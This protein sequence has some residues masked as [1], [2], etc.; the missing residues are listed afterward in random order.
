MNTQNSSNLYTSFLQDGDTYIQNLNSIL[1]RLEKSPDSKELVTQAFRNAHSLKS[2]AS[3]LNESEIAEAAHNMES[4]LDGIDPSSVSLD[5]E[6]FDFL[7]YSLDCINEMLSLRKNQGRELIDTAEEYSR[8]TPEKEVESETEGARYERDANGP[9]KSV[10]DHFVPEFTD[11]ERELLREARE[12]GERFLRVSVTLDESTALTYAKGY[13]ILNN[14]EQVLQV[15]KTDPPFGAGHERGDEDREY[16]KIIFYC[17]SDVEDVE[18]YHAVNVDQVERI[19]ISPLSYE[20]V[21]KEK[22][23]EPEKESEGS[24]IS[25][26][27]DGKSLYELNGYVD[28]LKIRIH[29]LKRHM[30][31]EREQMEVLAQIVNGLEEFAKKLSMVE[32]SEVLK[33]HFRM[34]R[35]LSAKLGKKVELSLEG[36]EVRVDRRAAEV[37]SEITVHLIRNA[38]DHG[39]ETPEER[40]AAGKNE[41]G[42]IVID[43][44]KEDDKLV[45]TVNDDGQG[46]RRE[47]LMEKAREQKIRIDEVTGGEDELLRFLVYPGLTTH[48]DATET[49]GRGYGLDLVFQKV[50]QFEGGGLSVHSDEEGTSFTVELP[51]GFSLLTL[52]IVR[53]GESLIAV[54]QQHVRDVFTIDRE[55]FSSD[56]K[57]ALLWNSYPVYTLDGRLY[58]TDISPTDSYGILI[59]YLSR[60]AIVLVDELMF[61]KEIPE[62]RLTLYIEGSPYLHRMEISGSTTRFF[63]LS[64]SI[65]TM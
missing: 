2:E 6:K 49:S 17:T 55:K 21:I 64:P 3:Y 48:D 54:P 24:D 37:L 38:L 8:D 50:R 19:L 13:L 9:A 18:I 65:V 46:I 31:G 60:R 41:T 59:D 28:E 52:Q 10:G 22:V 16:R 11:F 53:C 43:A 42:I 1:L 23:G 12:R 4:T 36:C 45:V 63:Y 33:P 20:S 7:F 26:K 29:R 15:L 30:S 5:R 51:A 39:I 47:E 35:D 58:H 62:D 27:I 44:R 57:G 32:L 25:V 40:A 14:L 61:K 56:E 34:V